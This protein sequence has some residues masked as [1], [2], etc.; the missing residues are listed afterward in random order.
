MQRSLH[1]IEPQFDSMNGTVKELRHI[2]GVQLAKPTEGVIEQLDDRWRQ[3]VSDC[4][5]RQ[6]NLQNLQSG[7]NGASDMLQGNMIMSSMENFLFDEIYL[8][9]N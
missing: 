3:L 8:I 6:D 7:G 5:L 2:H 4:Q 1:N 9:N